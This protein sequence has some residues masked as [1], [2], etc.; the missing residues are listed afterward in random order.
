MK[1]KK[2]LNDWAKELEADPKFKPLSKK[3][4]RKVARQSGL[5]PTEQDQLYSMLAKDVI[6]GFYEE[7]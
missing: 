1:Q 2:T 6:A 4:A 3:R 5:K 7:D